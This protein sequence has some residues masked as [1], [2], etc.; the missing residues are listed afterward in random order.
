MNKKLT[1]HSETAYIFANIII[2]F[3]VAMAT[4]ADFG[5]SMIVAPA[6][7]ISQK[8]TFLT[9]GQSEYVL[10]GLM[11]IV[12]CL[13]IKKF[14]LL[15]LFSFFTCLF[16]GALLDMW[17]IIIPHFNPNIT[18]VGSLPFGLRV[19]YFVAS[20][21]LT[22]LAIALFFR[23]Y[24]PP[25]VYEFFVKVMS[26]HFG[27]KLTRF[28]IGYDICSFLTGVALT[29]LFFGKFVG[30]GIGTII[31]T[32]VNGALIGAC[33]RL[34]DRYVEFKPLFSKFAAKFDL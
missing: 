9:F 5:I 32:A 3:S 6:Y 31:I 13:I 22:A 2:S 17:R 21:L 8:F 7:I 4:A 30:I 18:A 25:Q 11:F 16:Y 20:V 19:I 23:I 1:V 10:Q 12:M 15:H 28:K 26:E 29:L 27:I 34:L 33:G 24:I 14:K